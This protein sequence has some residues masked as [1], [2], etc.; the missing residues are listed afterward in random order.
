MT[1]RGIH[2][3]IR[4]AILLALICSACGHSVEVRNPLLVR[5]E[6][7]AGTHYEMGLQH[8]RLL[9]D[10]MK[11]IY[12]RFLT[13][14]VLPYLT[15]EQPFISDFFSYYKED[16]FLEGRF[17]YEILKEAAL[18]MEGHIPK[19]YRDEIRGLAE[20]SGV[21]YEEALILNTFLDSLLS[22]LNIRAILG[23]I[24]SPW[25]ARITFPEAILTDGIDNDEDGT[26]DEPGENVI[27]PVHYARYA[28]MKEIPPR[29]A[30][31]F[32]LRDYSLSSSRLGDGI[33]LDTMRVEVNGVLYTRASEGWW[34]DGCEKM[35]TIRIRP[36]GGFPAGGAVSIVIIAGDQLWSYDPPPANTNVCREQV[37]TF[38]TRGDGRSLRDVPNAEIPDVLG[39]AASANFAAHGDATRTGELIV[40]RHFALLDIDVAHKFAYILNYQPR[41]FATGRPLHACTTISWTGIGWALTGMNDSGLVVAVSR[42]ETLN[43]YSVRNIVKLRVL[44]EG[45]PIGF[46]LRYVLEH[47]DNLDDAE[48]YL[49]TVTPVNGWTILMTDA[50]SRDLRVVELVP[51]ILG[52]GIGYDEYGPDTADPE[53]LDAWGRPFASITPFDIRSSNV[54]M[55][56]VDDFPGLAQIDWSPGMMT[57]L[58]TM[59]YMEKELA[60]ALGDLDAI[61]TIELLRKDSLVQSRDSMHAAVLLPDTL[62][63]FVALGSRPAT[64]GVFQYFSRADLFPGLTE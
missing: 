54:F 41:D 26:V 21:P 62:S 51:D 1:V 28:V 18:S 11:H 38:S 10:K 59:H 13:M 44:P 52:Q 19:I 42:S 29:S 57:G 35:P 63:M 60:P 43:D 33:L 14:S 64:G 20:G 4:L 22:V 37:L 46:I 27:Q 5:S 48:A 17:G 50:K 39:N 31:E 6:H 34:D 58:R 53:N 36:P 49:R 45:C 25:L 12:T 56:K 32:T 7:F 24:Q 2:T 61:G 30:F 15:R 23:E 40:G 8:G 55:K 16:K 9:G 3:L 47:F